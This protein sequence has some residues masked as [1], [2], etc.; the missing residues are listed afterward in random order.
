TISKQEYSSLYWFNILCGLVLTVLAALL[1]NPISLFYNEPELNKIIPLTA[2]NIFF[3]SVA[4][5]QRTVQQKKINFKFISVVEI[6]SSLTMLALAAM[7][8]LYEYGVYSLVYSTVFSSILI[9]VIYLLYGVFFE[10]NL[11]LF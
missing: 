1:S 2:L 6:T 7:L 3:G 10:R 9:A 11:S 5:L 8:A 4:G